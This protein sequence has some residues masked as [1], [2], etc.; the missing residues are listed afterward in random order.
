MERIGIVACIGRGAL[1]AMAMT[2]LRQV[3]TGLGLMPQTPPESMAEATGLLGRVPPERR[4]AAIEVAHWG[5]GAVGGAMYALLPRS[6]RRLPG[7]GPLYGVAVWLGFQVGLAPILGLPQ[8]TEAS[9][10]QRGALLADHLLY[11]LVVGAGTS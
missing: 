3:S 7:V 4:T 1:G 5:Y 9:T 2:G 10:A 8:A 6:V 11:G